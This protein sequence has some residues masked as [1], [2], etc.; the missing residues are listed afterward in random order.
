MVRDRVPVASIF[1]KTEN[2]KNVKG[3]RDSRTAEAGRIKQFT[4]Q[5]FR[6]K[7]M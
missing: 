5:Y 2:I 3:Y 6:S 1:Y 4:I 7:G